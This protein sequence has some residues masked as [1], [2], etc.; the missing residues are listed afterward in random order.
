M[1]IGLCSPWLLAMSPGGY[2]CSQHRAGH[3]MAFNPS[4]FTQPAAVIEYCIFPGSH[5]CLLHHSPSSIQHPPYHWHHTR[6]HPVW[7]TESQAQ[8]AET[9]TDHG[10]L[11]R[12]QWPVTAR[13]V[14]PH[15]AEGARGLAGLYCGRSCSE[16]GV[17]R[18]SLC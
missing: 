7:H 3:T 5:P 11:I 15:A 17:R 16:V 1:E 13:E 9:L 4:L 12:R 8:L 14:Q 10:G 2:S 6:C 18:E